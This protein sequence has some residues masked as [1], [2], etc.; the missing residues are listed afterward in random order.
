MIK[1]EKLKDKY[2]INKDGV[3]MSL[4]PSQV[5]ELH[6]LLSEIKSSLP[7]PPTPPL[8]PNIRIIHEDIS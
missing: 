6:Y 8:Q 1:V 5:N 4:T 2:L 7:L 3:Y